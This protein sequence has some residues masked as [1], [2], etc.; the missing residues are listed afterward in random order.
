MIIDSHAHYAHP[1][2]DTEIPYLREENG[3]MK[4][5]RADRE[6]L[7]AELKKN[8]IAGVIE[9]SIGFDSIEKQ[10]TIV[11][12]HSDFMWATVG[13][14]P[15][16]CINTAWEKRRSVEKYAEKSDLI[17]IGETGLDYHYPRNQQHRLRQ[18]RWFVFQ[19]KLADKLNLPLILHVRAADRDALR[20]LKKHKARLHGGVAHCFSGDAQL[21]REYIG[22]G[23]A[24]GIGG[25]LLC[26]DEQGRALCDAV[27]HVPLSSIL[28]ETDAPFVLPDTDELQCSGKQRR[29]LCNSS[30]ILPAVIR[31]IAEIRG[32]AY[33]SV[34]DAIYQNTVRVF[35]LLT[36]GGG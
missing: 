24:I 31:R 19:I 16:R 22:L 6:A 33:A 25:R 8:G 1:R 3:A 4:V 27:K 2:F 18:K 5:C 23:F 14:H 7:L 26:N 15:T 11:S 13:V 9:P 35:G 32:E 12:E 36:A 17:A 29:K 34:E 20:I 21:A 10:L 30:L 28:V